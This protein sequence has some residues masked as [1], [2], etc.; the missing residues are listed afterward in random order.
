MTSQALSW[1]LADRSHVA[2]LQ[3]RDSVVV[4]RS[5]PEADLLID[6]P[7]V[8]RRH[9]VLRRVAAG[10]VLEHLSQTNPTR[11]NGAPVTSPVQL[12][13]GDRITVGPVEVTFHD[14][15]SKDRYSGPLCN[16]CHRENDSDKGDCWYCG[17]SLVN[18]PTTVRQARPVLCRLI[19]PDRS[20]ADLYATTALVLSPSG[21]LSSVK[22]EHRSDGGSAWVAAVDGRAVFGHPAASSADAGAQPVETGAELR[23][24]GAVF[25]ALVR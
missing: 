5:G 3:G 11:V 9:L 25:T 6:N 14:L 7:S 15:S 19:A 23:V 18:A 10:F 20:V 21:T 24:D 4:G 1:S 8:S 2:D 22:V 16:V 13:D 17:T 12:R